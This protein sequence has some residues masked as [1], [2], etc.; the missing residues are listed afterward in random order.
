MRWA[1]VQHPRGGARQQVQ[2]CASSY[3]PS[4]RLNNSRF[5]S[6]RQHS[7]DTSIRCTI[8]SCGIFM[9]ASLKRWWDAPPEGKHDSVRRRYSATWT[10]R[11]NDA[12]LAY[13]LRRDAV[14]V[15]GTASPGT[16]QSVQVARGDQCSRDATD[17]WS[18]ET[19][20]PSRTRGCW[21][22]N[23]ATTYNIVPA[24]VTTWD[25]AIS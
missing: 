9:K 14:M 16:R 10:Q 24:H 19:T 3:R 21:I 13:R 6:Q 2:S 23:C 17:P 7:S 4:S 12:D 11:A 1:S 22:R 25:M 18:T 20:G 8:T 5:N 15:T